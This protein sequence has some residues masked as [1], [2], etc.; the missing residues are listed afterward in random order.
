MS[1]KI[2][3]FSSNKIE[4]T[5]YIAGTLRYLV[6]VVSAFLLIGYNNVITFD[7]DYDY[8][9]LLVTISINLL[10]LFKKN[11]LITRTNDVV[12]AKVSIRFLG[13]T[14]FVLRES[15]YITHKITFLVETAD[16]WG[17]SKKLT[18]LKITD[19]NECNICL[20][21]FDNKTILANE[22]YNDNEWRL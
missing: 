20:G 22:I 8:T 5:G 13:L 2:K 12:T 1:E 21:V 16:C 19:L 14:V 6:F 18:V 10:L 3:T 11:I 7:Y 17:L 4:S 9:V 15:E